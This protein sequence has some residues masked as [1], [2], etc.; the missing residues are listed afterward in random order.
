MAD[1][2][3]PGVWLAGLVPI[4]LVV[5]IVVAVVAVPRKKQ[6]A[7]PAAQTTEPGPSAPPEVAALAPGATGTA[8]PPPSRAPP[9]TAAPSPPPVSSAVLLSGPPPEPIPELDALYTRPKGSD[10]WTAE[11][12]LAYREKLLKDLD[13][14]ERS[15]RS[16]IAHARSTGDAAAEKEKAATLSY[17]RARRAQFEGMI[18]GHDTLEDGGS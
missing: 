6:V 10:Q 17:L 1:R 18:R 16:E 8:Q 9:S 14:K 13:G 12:K 5:G 4:V 3:R 7:A 11:Q 15:L 2:I